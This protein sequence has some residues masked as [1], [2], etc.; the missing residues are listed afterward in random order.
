MKKLLAVAVLLAAVSLPSM[1]ATSPIKLS[2]WG[3][4]AWPA[5]DVAIKGLDLGIGST[6]NDMTGLQFNFIYSEAKNLTGVQLGLVNQVDNGEGLQWGALNIA[7]GHFSGVELGL[8]NWTGS[9]TGAQ[10]GWV[11]YTDK[12]N[13]FQLGLVN[14]AGSIGEG[15]QIG[16]V[17]FAQNGWFPVMIIVNGRF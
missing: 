1:A 12:L 15:L 4:I 10:L 16:L 8:V 5:Q 3:P 13:G 9:V 11:N 14:Y 6:T 2:L 7:T 17:N